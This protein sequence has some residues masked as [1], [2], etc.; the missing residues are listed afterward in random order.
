MQ[1]T[2]H[3]TQ[4]PTHVAQHAARSTQH[5][6]RSKL[7]QH[8]LAGVLADVVN[9]EAVDMIV[10]ISKILCRT[11][12]YSA[13]QR[14]RLPYQHHSWHRMQCVRAGKVKRAEY[15]ATW[16]TLLA[17]HMVTSEVSIGFQ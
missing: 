1:L 11:T 17:K 6:I 2:M 16:L 12:L 14:M 3:S 15:S 5:V 10:I 9:S 7:P 13:G 4:H 8:M